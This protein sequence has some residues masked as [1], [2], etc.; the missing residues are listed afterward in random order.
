MVLMV[1]EAMPASSKPP[2]GVDVRI[3][4]GERHIFGA[5][6]PSSTRASFLYIGRAGG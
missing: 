5:S 4:P 6:A 3:S 2:A 1:V